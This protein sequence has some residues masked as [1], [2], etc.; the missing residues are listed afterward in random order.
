[1]ILIDR[2][3]HDLIKEG[4]ILDADEKNIGAISYDLVIDYFIQEEVLEEIN[5]A[6]GTSAMVASKE[7]INVPKDKIF[8]VIPKN[9]RIRQGIQL[10]A[11]VYQPGHKTRVFARIT[12]VSSSVISIKKGDSVASIMI[13]SLSGIPARPYDGTFKDELDYR[14]LGRY[15]KLYKS[16]KIDKTISEIKETEKKIYSNVMLLITIFIGIFSFI[17][18]NIQSLFSAGS[19]LWHLVAYNLILVGGLGILVFF[20]SIILNSNSMQREGK[21]KK[22]NWCVLI[23]S[24][25]LLVCAIV[26]GYCSNCISI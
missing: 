6:P 3:I 26:V 10:E 25:L 12:N 22:R 13:E 20:V 7:I 24:V 23:I 9:S 15:S 16:E 17:N 14:G 21:G 5:L 1:M 11:P 8:R 2:E 18:L 19:S 4:I